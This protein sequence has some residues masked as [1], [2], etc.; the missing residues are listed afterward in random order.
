ME[1]APAGCCCHF[2]VPGPLLRMCPAHKITASHLSLKLLPT[3]NVLYYCGS[4]RSSEASR[5]FNQI[6]PWKYWIFSGSTRFCLRKK[7]CKVKGKTRCITE[8]TPK[9][10][11]IGHFNQ[12]LVC[13][14]ST[15]IE[16]LQVVEAAVEFPSPFAEVMVQAWLPFC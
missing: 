7:S 6:F 8:C 10:A 9:L 5:M 1:L 14:L 2:F 13:C 12:S 4:I 16:L 15:S 3:C 11:C